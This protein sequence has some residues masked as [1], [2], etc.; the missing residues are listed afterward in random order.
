MDRALLLSL[1]LCAAAS[2]SDLPLVTFDRSGSASSHSFTELNDPVMGGQSTGTWSLGNGYGIF[3]GE[4]VDVPSLSAPGFIKAASDGTFPDASS[5]SGG[6]LILSVRSTTPTYA[7]FRVALASGTVAPSYACAGGGSIPFSRGCF[8][9]SFKV[10][11]GE[12]FSEVEVPLSSFSDMWSPAT[13]EHSKECSED[14]TVCL[15]AKSLSGIK[16]VELWA[17]GVKGKIHLEVAAITFRTASEVTLLADEEPSTRPPS[18]FDACKAPVQP[19]LRYSISTRFATYFPNETMAEAVCCDSR[20]KSLAE[21]QFL[22]EAPDI[23]LFSKLDTTSGVTTFYDSVCGLPVFRAPVNRTQAEFEADTQ[24]HGWP[25][26]RPAEIVSQ[27]IVTDKSTGYVT[28][29]CG[30]HL[31]SFLPDAQG[32]R[33]CIDLSCISG[34]PTK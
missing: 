12:T 9:A 26:F 7:G 20:M 5:F 11:A 33:W 3:D 2:A 8:K 30:T 34:N 29:T 15:A 31:G 13:G 1:V 16:R 21:T 6:S 28:S 22:F 32:D 10:P 17:E 14:T 23:A 27:N 18:Q 24:E 25:S 4:V 19:D